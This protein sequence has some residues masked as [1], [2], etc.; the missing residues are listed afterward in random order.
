MGVKMESKI[1]STSL[2]CE[3]INNYKSLLN[4]LKNCCSRVFESRR[5]IETSSNPEW[6]DI[7]KAN[8]DAQASE[9]AI[10]QMAFLEPTTPDY[11]EAHD[12]EFS[13]LSR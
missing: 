7:E 9:L 5:L 13:G 12:H 4:D 11:Y 3:T 10:M 8:K 2:S 6:H 1:E